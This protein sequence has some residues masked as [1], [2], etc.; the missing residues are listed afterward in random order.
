MSQQYTIAQ[1]LQAEIAALSAIPESND[2]EAAI[3]LILERV[4]RGGGRLITSGMGKA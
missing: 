2:Y 3:A 1:I 4:H